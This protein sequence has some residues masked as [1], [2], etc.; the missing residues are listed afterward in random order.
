ME[1]TKTIV[2]IGDSF[3][4][5]DAHLEESNFILKE[6]Y[7]TRYAKKLHFD[8]H[9]INVGVNGESTEG[10]RTN[11][12]EKGDIYTILLGTNDWWGSS[13]PIG[14]R[15]DFLNGK[16]E[17]IVGNLGHLIKR[18]FLLSPNAEIFLGTPLP[19]GKFV[20]LFDFNNNADSSA[21]PRFGR[22]LEEVAKGICAHCHGQGIHLIDCY[23]EAGFTVANSVNFMRLET[24]GGIQDVLYPNYL[25]VEF[26]PKTK[27][28]P[29]PPESWNMTYDGLHP[30]DKGSEALALLFADAI[31]KWFDRK[32]VCP[33]GLSSKRV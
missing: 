32:C 25:Y 18:I 26:N 20:Y 17:T 28:Y 23:H 27:V 31:N 15:E 3:T 6:G 29:Y 2:A 5:I 13:R 22:T 30:T 11:P 4:Y 9:I 14:T 12:I 16:D 21:K 24:K 8:S 7:V 10:F 19:R 1:K 33:L